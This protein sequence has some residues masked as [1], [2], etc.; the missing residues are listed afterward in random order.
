MRLRRPRWQRCC[1]ATMLFSGLSVF[2]GCRNRSCDLQASAGSV[3]MTRPPPFAFLLRIYDEGSL[4]GWLQGMP[5]QAILRSSHPL[6]P[7]VLSIRAC[8]DTANWAHS[9][10]LSGFC[11]DRNAAPPPDRAPISP[12]IRSHIYLRR[13]ASADLLPVP[14][15]GRSKQAAI[16]A[17]ELRRAFVTDGIADPRNISAVGEQQATRLLKA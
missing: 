9:G 1:A 15:G 12:R 2:P 13:E 16:L 10:Q 5:G 14:P 17:T 7:P 11:C 3:K 4:A 8:H 6:W